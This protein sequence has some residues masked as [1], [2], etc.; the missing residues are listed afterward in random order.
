MNIGRQIY[1]LRKQQRITQEKLAAEMGV[2]VGAISK[3]ETG[4]AMPDIMMLCAL[5]DYFHVTSD[6]LLGRNKEW[7]FIIC[8]DAEFIRKMLRQIIDKEGY[9]K[10]RVV[11]NGKQLLQAV[12][13]KKPHM[14]F[15]DINLPDVSGL[16]LLQKLKMLDSRVKIIMI[17]ADGSEITRKQ[18]I[19][20][21]AEAF[22]SKPFLPEYV[23]A[24]IVKYLEK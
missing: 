1:L 10:V 13:V 11:E 2:S 19:S 24:N 8:D 18:A 20:Y 23:V 14:I 3:W 4:V 5:A 21:G 12:E 16:E 9:G 6:E 17:S 22:I 7:D 15:L